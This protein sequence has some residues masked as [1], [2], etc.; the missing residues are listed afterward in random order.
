MHFLKHLFQTTILHGF[1]NNK[2][3]VCNIWT[4]CIL[5]WNTMTTN[6]IFANHDT[7]E[8]NYAPPQTNLIC[9]RSS[10]IACNNLHV[11]QS[12]HAIG[13]N[14]QAYFNNICLGNFRWDCLQVVPFFSFIW[15]CNLSFQQASVFWYISLAVLSMYCHP[16]NQ[17]LVSCQ[18]QWW[19]QIFHHLLSSNSVLFTVLMSASS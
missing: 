3:V 7:Y 5:Y 18:L 6:W 12:P 16:L 13:I 15:C 11:F 19:I 17:Q 9:I 14:Q 8:F 10:T 4:S 2:L 1:H